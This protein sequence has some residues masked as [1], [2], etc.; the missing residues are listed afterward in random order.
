MQDLRELCRLRMF[1]N[2]VLKRIF[3]PEMDEVTRKWRRIR[4]QELNYLYSSC[5]IIRFITSRRMRRAG[6][7]AGMGKRRGAYR[8]LVGKP[9]VKRPLLKPRRSWENNIEMD[10]QEV[11]QWHGL[12]LALN[13]GVTSS[14]INAGNFLNG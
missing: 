5:N 3:G 1:E 10:L 14:S 11:E 12:A 9:E 6:H 8:V 7:V 4:N 13:K 2:R